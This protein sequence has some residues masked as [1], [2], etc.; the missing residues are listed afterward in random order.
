MSHT[1]SI[2]GKETANSKARGRKKL[3]LFEKE[4]VY[5]RRL[6]HGWGDIAMVGVSGRGLVREEARDG[7]HG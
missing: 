5:C 7:S 2:S 3:D 4:P 6:V 1:E